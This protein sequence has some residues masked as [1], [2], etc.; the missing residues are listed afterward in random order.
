MC[1][2]SSCLFTYICL[3][4]R[5]GP[6]QHEEPWLWHGKERER[7]SRYAEHALLETCRLLD[8]RAWI[9]FGFVA[10]VRQLAGGVNVLSSTGRGS[11]YACCTWHLGGP[12]VILGVQKI[13]GCA[14]PGM[15][16]SDVV[17]WGF[18]FGRLVLWWLAWRLEDIF[19]YFSECITYSCMQATVW[20]VWRAYDL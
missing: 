6:L 16:V 1:T 5:F 18:A 11:A 10:V 7:Y 13:Q 15:E 14:I 8:K 19:V 20:R 9:R 4:I 3:L 2:S 12:E 17:F